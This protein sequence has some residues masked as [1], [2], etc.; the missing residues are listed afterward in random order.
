MVTGLMRSNATASLDTW[1]LAV[2]LSV[3]PTL[4][5]SFIE[6]NPDVDRVIATAADP[7][8]IFDSWFEYRC[9]R[10]MPVYAIPGLLGRF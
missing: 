8:M 1:H 4:N 2:D 3:T 10:P 7:H 6:D 9:V 5:A